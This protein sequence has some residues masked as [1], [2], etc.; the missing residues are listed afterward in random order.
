[1]LRL[2]QF[3]NRVAL[4]PCNRP[5]LKPD[6]EKSTEALSSGLKST[7]SGS[8]SM[9]SVLAES[10]SVLH[11][12]TICSAWAAKGNNAAKPKSAL[13]SMMS[14]KMLIRFYCMSNQFR[15]APEELPPALPRPLT[16]R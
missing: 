10:L 5:A 3:N 12:R 4:S 13:T 15:V 2:L 7:V 6:D 11:G 9:T 8:V 16:C 1:M 14:P